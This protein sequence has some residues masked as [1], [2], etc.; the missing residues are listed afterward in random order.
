MQPF[1][2]VARTLRRGLCFGLLLLWSVPALAQTG[3][4]TGTLVDSETGEPLIGANVQ[5][6]GTAIGT[7]TDI[8][9]NYTVK[10]IEPGT[11]DF[12]FSYIGYNPTTVENV[13]VVAGETKRLDLALTPEAVGME[14]VVVEASALENTEAALL[15]QR[16][17]A[18]S[19]SDAISAEAIGRSG[20]GDAADAM[21][22]VTGASVVDGKYVYVRGLGDRYMT[23]Q[24]NGASLPSADPDRNSVSLDLFPSGALD[25]IIT[26]KSFTPDKPGSF[27]GG[28]VDIST[29]AFPEQFTFSVSSSVGYNT[30]ATGA[31]N[32]LSYDGGNLSLLDFD[33]DDRAIPDVWQNRP[34]DAEP[35][36]DVLARRDPELASDL[37]ALA[38]AFDP[39]MAPTTNTAPLDRSFSI[40]TG[41]QTPVFGRPFGFHVGVSY[42]QSY[43]FY[44]DGRYGEFKLT[45]SVEDKDELDPQA[46][47]S[48]AR[49]TQEELLGGLA[50]LSYK[51]TPN[52]I[53]GTIFM[54]NRSAESVAQYQS[55]QLQ[56][57]LPSSS[58]FE[59][60]VLGYTERLLQSLQFN[61]EHYFG[62]LGDLRAEWTTSLTNTTQEEPDLRFF[63]NQINV[64]QNGTVDSVYAIRTSNYTAPSRYF[65]DLEE[66]G[67]SSKLDL[68]VPLGRGNSVKVG[69]AYN[70]RERDFNENLFVYELNP[71]QAR[72]DGDPDRFFSEMTGVIDTTTV[73]DQQR[74][75]IGNYIID[76]TTPGNNYTGD[77][78]VAAAYGMVDV[79]PVRNL[80]VIAGA[81]YE[82]TEIEVASENEELPAGEISEGDILPSLNL[83]YAL[84]DN[85]NL[86]AA[87]GRTLARPVFRE[88]APYS[89]FDFIGGR[90]FIGNPDLER[91]LIDNLDLRWE[92]FTR[93]GEILAISG[94]YKRLKNPIEL[95]IVSTNNQVQFQNVD[96]ATVFGAEFEARKRLDG[97][98]TALKNVEVGANLSLVQSVVDIPEAELADIR[99]L[100]PDADDKRPL[101]G[102]SP[103]V[104]NVDVGY[105]NPETGTIASLY[106]N[107][108]GRRLSQ[109]A[110]GGT[111]DIYEEPAGTLDLIVSQRMLS[112]FNVKLSAKN[113]LDPSIQ[114]TQGFKDQDFIVQDYQR[115]RSLSLSVT[116]AIN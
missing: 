76:A 17:K 30:E 93:P 89:S 8:D 90:I 5:I 53:L 62:G 109:V 15:K 78:Q 106:Y 25:N 20:A 68:T 6:D 111:P 32:F 52:H 3:T 83:V 50:N 98:A 43:N 110:I 107:I 45:G 10:A 81:R 29:K 49:G 86:R 35:I 66:D 103:Y 61:G 105:S 16:Q 79:S 31:D 67:W 27:A 115:G 94:Y 40:S 72:Y 41:N 85:M 74:F 101:Q 38:T 19:V 57:D 88:L 113:L 73:G 26:T 100:D 102:Q 104:L 91:T 1:A 4:V 36:I 64:I 47:L 24:L 59:T 11:Y 65:R 44:D 87:Y 69:G 54:Y 84:Q 18:S 92:W 71:A 97:L 13:E 34:E 82:T 21:E 58:I 12:V 116:Y 28:S 48:D 42:D 14:E 99:A 46:T 55:G 75:T 60:R 95:A 56:R 2:T 39:T 70:L 108:F 33:A 112:N 23:T 37:N 9:G 114:E 22:K 7:A 77:Q 96:Q 80:R 51:V 63:A